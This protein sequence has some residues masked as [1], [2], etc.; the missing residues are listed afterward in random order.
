MRGFSLNAAFGTFSTKS[1]LLS[2]NSLGLDNVVV[3]LTTLDKR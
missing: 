3:Q 2:F 1:R